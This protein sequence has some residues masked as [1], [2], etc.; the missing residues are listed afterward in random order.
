MSVGFFFSLTDCRFF[1][2]WA[3]AA[4][5]AVIEE[6]VVLFVRFGPYLTVFVHQSQ[7]ASSMSVPIT[8]R[9]AFDSFWTRQFEAQVPIVIWLHMAI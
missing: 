1:F 6:A 4:V 7:L 2:A 8:R 3:V 5:A 9:L